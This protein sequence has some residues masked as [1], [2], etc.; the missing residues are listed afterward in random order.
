MALYNKGNMPSVG[1]SSKFPNAG[2][3]DALPW[4]R[5]QAETLPMVKE[6]ISNRATKIQEGGNYSSL[7]RNLVKSSGVYAL[8]SL[9]SPL[10]SL[11]LAPFLTRNLSNEMY[12]VLAVLNTTTALLAGVTQLGLGSAFF[13]SYNYDY[14]SQKDRLSVLSTVLLLLSLTSLCTSFVMMLAAPWL[15]TLLFNNASFSKAVRITALVVLLQNLTVPGFSWMRAENRALFFSLL[16]IANLGISLGANILLVGLLHMGIIGSLIATGCGY[17]FVGICTVPIILLHSGLNLRF[18]IVRGLLSFGLPN[19]FN[20]GSMW[21]LQLSDRILLSR[22]G[23][24]SQTASYS[25]AY[26]LGSV[27]SVVV[28]SPFTLAWP[29]AMFTI[30]RKNDAPNVFKLVFRWYGVILL[31]SAFALIIVS[32]AALYVFFP[33]SY[34]SAVFIIPI[35][36]LST[37][38]YGVYTIFTTG[39]SIQRKTWFAV[40]FTTLSALANIGFNL[41]LIPLFGSIGA[42]LSTLLAYMLLALIAYVVNQRLYSIPY[43]IGF[44]CIELLVGIVFYV[45]SSMLAPRQGTYEAW[46]ISA[47]ALALYGVC[48]LLLGRRSMRSFRLR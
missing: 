3:L 19:V 46:S 30:A 26:S 33:P 37:V 42:A 6:S 39:I 22:L 18:D 20:F 28:L 45:G 12:G 8:S 32:T 1:K 36:V 35:I 31:F 7:F 41:I 13:R 40:I 23:S 16:S 47:A 43:E 34:H 21:V 44:F 9:A 10:V 25:V 29:S 38:L 14:E 24:L 2:S 48:L 15:S 11:V 17:A 5:E 4:D 27:V